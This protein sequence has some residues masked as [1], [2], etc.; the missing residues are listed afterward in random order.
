MFEE[1][2]PANEF[3]KTMKAWNS[4]MKAYP[5]ENQKVANFVS[6]RLRKLTQ[7]DDSTQDEGAGISRCFDVM[8]TGFHRLIYKA[9]LSLQ[10]F[11]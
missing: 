4:E 6:S 3:D 9:G 10:P 1:N 8:T 7:D 11:G 5:E 2:F